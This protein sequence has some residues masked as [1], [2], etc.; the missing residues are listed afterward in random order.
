MKNQKQGVITQDD[1]RIEIARSSNVLDLAHQQNEGKVMI[2]INAK[3]YIAIRPDEDPEVAK[4][5]FIE[6]T[7][8]K[9]KNERR[10]GLQKNE[11]N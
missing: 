5:R 1:K 7:T 8:K 10:G 9:I 2:R 6:R 4:Q 3:T 11:I